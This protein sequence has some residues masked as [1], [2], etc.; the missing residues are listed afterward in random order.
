MI[1]KF[2]LFILVII[3]YFKCDGLY[4]Y[5]KIS[6]KN[7]IGLI[8]IGESFRIGGQGSRETDKEESIKEQIESI[9]SHCY[10]MDK[11]KEADPLVEIDIFV[12]TFSTRYDKYLID[13][14]NKSSADNK[15]YNII[16]NNLKKNYHNINDSLYEIIKKVDL[17]IYDYIY[18]M[19][20]DLILKPLFNKLAIH[21]NINKITFPSINHPPWHKYVHD[22]KEYPLI[23]MIFVI[24]PNKYK[25]IL[26]EKLIDLF[27]HTFLHKLLECKYNNE[28]KLTL[29]NIHI[30]LKTLHDADSAKDWQPLY[31]IANRPE[32]NNWTSD[33]LYYNID[34]NNFIEVPNLKKEEI[35]TI[36]NL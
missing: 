3:L 17:D 28:D 8:F 32:T 21:T 20:L 31:K 36:N 4:E 27:D 25:K 26:E 15:V 14:Y 9:N 6:K 19:R 1:V 35:Y 2:I 18:I 10:F 34:N 22:D 29:N 13:K 24:I 11:L 5:F 33:N 16:P 23:N 12:Q 30:L 7:K